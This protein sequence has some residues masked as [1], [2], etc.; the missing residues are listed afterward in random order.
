MSILIHKMAGQSGFI[1]IPLALMLRNNRAAEILTDL[2]EKQVSTGS[3]DVFWPINLGKI[4]SMYQVCPSVVMED[5]NACSKYLELKQSED[6][7]GLH[8]LVHVDVLLRDLYQFVYK[9]IQCKQK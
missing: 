1:E 5:V 4:A 8:A 6:T 9:E 3:M 7:P 2:I